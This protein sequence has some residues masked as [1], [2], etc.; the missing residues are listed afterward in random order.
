MESLPG[1]RRRWA[2]GGAVAVAALLALAA[3]LGAWPFGGTLSREEFVER[4][5][6][7][8]ADAHAEFEKLQAE[9]PRS[10]SDAAELT[11]ELIEVAE[12]EH[13]DLDGLAEP[14]ELSDLVGR[15]LAAR[16]QGIEVMR[17]GL[18]A[19]EAADARGYE[20]AQAQL[21]RSQ[22]DPRHRLARRIGFRQCSR[23]LVGPDELSRQA[24]PPSGD[25]DAPPVGAGS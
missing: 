6:E 19:A 2:L 5:D 12:D 8:C 3:A 10:A 13:S 1:D 24:R 4:G 18:E 23:P 21:A 25:L 15:Y 9:P 7:I 17:E 16:Q 14:D 11:G 20:A 22:R